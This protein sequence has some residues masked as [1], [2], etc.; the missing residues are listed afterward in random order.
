[1]TTC[2]L[3]A[4]A[5]TLDKLKI[6]VTYGADAVYFGGQD[7]CLRAKAGNLSERELE[8]AIAYTRARGVKSYV[9]VNIFAKNQ[10]IDKLTNYLKFLGKL[11]P[12]ALIVSDPGVIALA[13]RIT[14]HI[15]LHL[16]TQ[17]NT[18]NYE[19]VR[20][21]QTVGMKRVNLARELGIKEIATIR[22][23]CPEMELEVFVHGAICIAYSGRCM[24]SLYLTGRE[25]NR[26]NCAHPCRYKYAV[27]EEKRPGEFFPVEEDDRGLYIFNSRDLCLLRRIP[28]LMD[29]GVNSLKIEGRMKGI[30]YLATVVRVYR[31]AL[32]AASSG[33]NWEDT[34]EG[35]FEQL[36]EISSR[37]YTENFFDGPPT[38]KDMIY[39]GY[40]A[41]QS[42][43]PVGII[44]KGGQRP[45]IRANHVIEPGDDLEYMARDL[46]DRNFTVVTITDA[47]T[48]RPLEKTIGGETVQ[49]ET[50]PAINFEEYALIRRKNPQRAD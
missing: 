44:L 4:P 24:L 22:R 43:I 28:E 38:K 46:R 1:M 20:F 50:S 21:W 26:G 42:Y 40:K 35:L 34:V 9:T 6:A 27:Q 3:L 49:I 41:P 45:V 48:G 30:L 15:P 23:H 11:G 12:D 14:P 10:D 7:F 8:E 18:L 47:S 36:C 17:A 33:K 29:V 25:A 16:S 37:G 2:E 13:Q 19:A 39:Q 32:D 5:G 31:A